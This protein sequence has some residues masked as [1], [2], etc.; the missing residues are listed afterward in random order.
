M[1]NRKKVLSGMQPTGKM[2]LGH[3]LGVLTNYAK[4]QNEFDCHFMVANWHSMTVFYPNYHEAHSYIEPMIADWLAVGIDPSKAVIFIQSEVKAHAEL[5]L[6]LSMYT[7]VPWLNRNPTYKE[8]Q[9]NIDKDIDSLGFLGYPVLQAADILLYNAELVPIGEDQLPHLEL[10]REIAR[11]FNK[12]NGDILTIPKAELSRFPKVLGTDGRKM[13]KSYLNT[14]DL[15]EDASSLEKKIKKM[16]T[17]TNRIRRDDVGNPEQCSLFSYYDFFYP[18]KK[19]EIIEGC[20]S[21]S[22]GCSDCKKIIFSKIE[23]KLLP[24]R[25]EKEKLA[26]N[27]SYIKDILNE[28]S[29][30]ANLIANETLDSIKSSMGLVIK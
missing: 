15:S 4:M 6:I 12:Y 17:D 20:T 8:K 5:N 18:E 30:K 7:P 23:E 28:G 9:E 3:Y 13:S 29:K 22:I 26:K 19:Q 25:E 27:N 11:R 24:F 1:K 16:K 10:T 21:A 14:I 2:H